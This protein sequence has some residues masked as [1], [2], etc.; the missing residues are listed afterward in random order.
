MKSLVN[1]VKNICVVRVVSGE[2]KNS[3]HCWRLSR[4]L[5]LIY[6]FG[7]AAGVGGGV[8]AWLPPW[9]GGNRG[10]DCQSLGNRSKNRGRWFWIRGGGF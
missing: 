10:G 8:G 9:S 4:F 1:R 3:L 5:H 7:V 2:N 6:G